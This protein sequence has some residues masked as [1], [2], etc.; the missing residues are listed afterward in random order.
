MKIRAAVLEDVALARAVKR[1][2]SRGSST[3]ISAGAAPPV[4]APGSSD[5]GGGVSS[6]PVAACT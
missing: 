3:V 5:H 6:A 4:S 2:Q 1:A